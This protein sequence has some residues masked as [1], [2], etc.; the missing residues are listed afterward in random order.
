MDLDVFINDVNKKGTV[1]SMVAIGKKLDAI[2]FIVA[3]TD[4]TI[5]DAEKIVE[6]IR[7]TEEYEKH[8]RVL[9]E[10]RERSEYWRQ[11]PPVMFRPT[12]EVI[13][14]TTTIKRH[15]KN[16]FHNESTHK[17]Q[18]TIVL[19]DAENIGAKKCPEI[20]RQANEMGVIS[21]MRYFA[22]KDDDATKDWKAMA[23]KYRIKPIL[24]E[25]EPEKNK[26][27]KLIIKHAKRILA[28]NK[29]I[30]IFC[31]SSNDGDY[32]ELV[33]ELKNQGKRVVILADNTSK[34]LEKVASCVIKI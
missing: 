2:E 32:K 24:S 9:K 20:V 25:G 12:T 29:S 26:I 13:H 4:C 31:I 19:I 11:H 27:D 17:K 5:I 10:V 15:E 21:E 18:N 34:K 30:D 28:K 3:W 16:R 22:R 23:S 8:L 6:K 33:E 7:L 1:I 14:S